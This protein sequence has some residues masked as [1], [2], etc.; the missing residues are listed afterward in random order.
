VVQRLLQTTGINLNR[1]GVMRE[2]PQFQKYIKDYR[3]FVL[4]GLIFEDT[5][6]DGQIETEKINLFMM[7]SPVITM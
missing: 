3:I 4:S 7:N 6:F 5:I 2:L 1:G